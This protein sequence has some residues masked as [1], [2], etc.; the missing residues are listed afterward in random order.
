MNKSTRSAKSA[1]MTNDELSAMALVLEGRHG[2]L[3]AEVAEFFSCT[4][5]QNADRR[6]GVAWARVADIVREREASRMGDA[7]RLAAE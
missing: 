7:F 4:H 3:A 2:V 6:R 5:L 1:T